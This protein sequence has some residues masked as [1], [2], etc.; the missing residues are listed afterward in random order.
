MNFAGRDAPPGRPSAIA[1]QRGPGGN[2]LNVGGALAPRPF[3]LFQSRPNPVNVIM[4]LQGL[5]KFTGFDALL[6]R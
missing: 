6:I 2:A 3:S 5:Q 4:I 1:R